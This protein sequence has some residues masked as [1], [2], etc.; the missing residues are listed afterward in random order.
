M[1]VRILGEGQLE[2]PDRV[3]AE[4]NEL[5]PALESAVADNDEPAFDQVLAY[6]LG[7][8]RAFGTPVPDHIVVPSLAPGFS[9]SSVF[10]THPSLVR[11]TDPPDPESLVTDLHAVN[12]G[13]L[14]A[15]FGSAPAVHR[16]LPHRRRLSAGA[17]VPVQTGHLVPLRTPW[18]GNVGTT[19]GS[20]R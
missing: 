9:L 20:C 17:G 4:L 18:K 19:P 13:L 14:E 8:V 16:D 7:R 10:S 1:I 11:R 12:S 2:L 15:G 3:V 6:L 5:D